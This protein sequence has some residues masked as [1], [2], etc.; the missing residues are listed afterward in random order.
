MGLRIFDYRGTSPVMV[1]IL[2]IPVSS[3]TPHFGEE[4]PLSGTKGAGA[5]FFSNCNLRCTYCQ[6]HQISY[7]RIGE[8]KYSPEA[9]ADEMLKL[10]DRGCHNIDLVSPS[11]LIPGVR[12]TLEIAKSR[13]LVIPKLP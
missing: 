1:K 5:I 3:I 2:H 6:N 13:G 9:L 11:H 10:Q 7:S 12:A 8:K 4:P